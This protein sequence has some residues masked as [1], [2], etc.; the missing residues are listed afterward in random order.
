MLNRA[1]QIIVEPRR[2][3]QSRVI[4][5]DELLFNRVGAHCTVF[6]KIY[7]NH[8]SYNNNNNNNNKIVSPM[9]LI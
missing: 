4:I 7:N 9:H 6:Y 1:I 8:N 5:S 2:S 3:Q